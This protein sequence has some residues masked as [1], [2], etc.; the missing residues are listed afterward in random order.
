MI[1]PDGSKVYAIGVAT[2]ASDREATGS[3]GV[4]VFDAATLASVDQW[5][6]TADFVSL[7]VS[8]N[9]R[10]VY[11]AGMP[12]VE[13]SGRGNPG[14]Q[15]SITVFDTATGEQRLIAGELGNDLLLFESLI[16]D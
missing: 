13:A 7:A 2:G 8:A 14:M 6:P 12:G 16:L 9:G 5:A 15:A 11:A 4:F 3:T 10:F 1:S